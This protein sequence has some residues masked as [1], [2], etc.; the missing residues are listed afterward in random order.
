MVFKTN[1][2]EPRGSRAS[3]IQIFKRVKRSLKN[4]PVLP[5]CIG[6]DELKRAKTEK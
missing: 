1:T 5:M 4:L 6:A 2:L 3:Q